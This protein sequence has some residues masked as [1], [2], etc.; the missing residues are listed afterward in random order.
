MD[1]CTPP[2]VVVFAPVARADAGSSRGPSTLRVTVKRRH[3]RLSAARGGHAHRCRGGWRRLPSMLKVSA[4]FPGLRPGTYPG[5]STS[6][7][8]FRAQPAVGRTSAAAANT[9]TATLAVAISEQITVADQ[10]ADDRR[11]NGFTQT[12]TADEIDALSDDPDEMAEQLAQM[13]GPGRA[14]VRGR[15]PRR[16]PA[17]EGS[18]SADSLQQQL[19]L[20]RVPR[21]RHGPRRGDHPARH[22]RL[23]RPRQLRLPRRVAERAQRL[24]A[25]ARSR[26]S[27]SATGSASRARSP[28]ARPASRCRWTATT[29]TT[30]APSARSRRATSPSTVSPGTRPTASMRTSASI[31]PSARA[32]RSAPSTSAGTPTAATS[33]WGTSTC[34]N[35][36][37]TPTGQRHLPRAQHR[38]SSARRCSAS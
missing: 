15:L 31:T 35:A 11:D 12:L 28:R 3:R 30:R 38:A 34:R 13:A 16:P 4:T 23:A 18:D 27:R 10:A 9:A 33:A 37:T 22:G 1:R 19:V 20:G 14:G 5:K 17:A 32:A 2:G 21:S 24:L 25:G 36:P 8:G 7:D 6:A 26:R 29:P